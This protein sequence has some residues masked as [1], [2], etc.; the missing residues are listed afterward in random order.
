MSKLID[1]LPNYLSE[2]KTL[3]DI[4][5]VQEI[6]LNSILED[7]NELFDNIFI[8]TMTEY[9][10]SK[11]ENMLDIKPF[12]NDTLSSRRNRI[13]DRLG[14]KLPYTMETIINKLNL[15]ISPDLYEID[16]E[17]HILNMVTDGLLNKE[18]DI[19]DILD[20]YLPANVL[21]NL[22]HEFY[23]TKNWKLFLGENVVYT[24]KYDLS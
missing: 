5:D 13:L 14:T 16:L 21:I 17:N 10:L 11:M 23:E 12:K 20:S 9:G 24:H 2:Y 15:K 22:I 7:V 8:E 4:L 6:Y 19:L 3:T 1:Y 18:T